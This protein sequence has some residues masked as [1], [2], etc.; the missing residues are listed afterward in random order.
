[1]TSVFPGRTR[2]A[3]SDSEAISDSTGKPIKSLEIR[4]AL[5]RDLDECGESRA[6]I[7]MRL[8]GELRYPVTVA[9]IDALVSQTKA[10][11][12]PAEWVAAWV[13]ATGSRR[14][15]DL[16]CEQLGLSAATEEDRQFAQLGRHRLA[17]QKLTGQLWEK[18]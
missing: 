12:L 9:Q 14:V 2:V 6:Q 18:I 7:A 1:M 5:A 17:E 8:A 10:N 4:L 13:T 15:L 16:L 11:R 3:I